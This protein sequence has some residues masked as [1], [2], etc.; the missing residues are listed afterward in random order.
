MRHDILYGYDLPIEILADVPKTEEVLEVLYARSSES[1]HLPI[2]ITRLRIVGAYPETSVVYRLFE[3]NYADL[4][5]VHVK[6]TRGL[7]TVLTLTRVGGEKNL[8]SGVRN[9]PEEMRAA[10]LTLRDLLIEKI[11]G[12]WKFLHRQSLLTDEYLLRESDAVL[13]SIPIILAEDLFEDKEMPGL[14]CYEP[15]ERLFAHFPHVASGEGV[16]EDV[17]GSGSAGGQ[18]GTSA[19][20]SSRV[21]RMIETTA[22]EVAEA[23]IAYD[24]G[25][26][27][28]DAAILEGRSGI[29]N[30]QWANDDAGDALILPERRPSSR[31]MGNG[32][33]AKLVSEPLVPADDDDSEVYVTQNSSPKELKEDVAAAPL[34]AERSNPPVKVSLSIPLQRASSQQQMQNAAAVPP[35][36]MEI[37]MSITFEPQDL[38]EEKMVDACL[39][40]LKLLRNTGVITEDE[41]KERCLRLFKS[42]SA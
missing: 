37:P 27:M 25:I 23:I 5:Q 34:S 6:F 36:R 15:T 19:V 3:I 31:S 29:I 41:Y 16:F 10:L 8:F 33:F 26:L 28:D 7:S 38:F 39:E 21:Q 13:S 24:P 14:G 30:D 22:L 2:L 42:D 35:D 4:L 17:P 18:E 11:G 32:T 20:M 40:S 12:E 1:Y 9:K